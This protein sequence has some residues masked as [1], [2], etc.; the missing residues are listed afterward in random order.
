M[1]ET[2]HRSLD[3]RK[4]A[5]RGARASSVVTI[6]LTFVGLLSANGAHA[7]DTGDLAKAAQN[8]V[9]NMISLPF[10]Y[11]ASLDWGP[12]GGTLHT[13]NIQPVWPFSNGKVNFIN[14]TIV[15]VVQQPGLA[16][17]QG[18]QFGLG[19]ITHT[20]FLSPA[21]SAQWAWRCPASGWWVRWS[22]TYGTSPAMRRST[23]SC[24]STSSTTTWP[25]AGT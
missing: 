9:A 8:P 11:N 13:L 18:S 24:S 17:G 2:C 4:I 20:L 15:P 25:V 12:E 10:Q 14:R 19:D 22:R 5:H 21:A 23:S 6:V 3:R 1:N 7:Q 16:P